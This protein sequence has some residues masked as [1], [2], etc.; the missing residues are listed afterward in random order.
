MNAGVH[1]ARYP[2]MGVRVNQKPKKAKPDALNRAALEMA[3]ETARRTTDTARRFSR[4]MS[5]PTFPV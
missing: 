1:V 4:F 3:M 5:F 2:Q